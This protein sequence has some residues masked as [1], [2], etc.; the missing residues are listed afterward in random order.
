M[1]AVPMGIQG[2]HMSD[3]FRDYSF[4]GW[5]RHWRLEKEIGLREM[6][7]AIEKDPAHYCKIE[8]SEL[9]PPKTREDLARLTAPLKLN[10]DQFEM[11]VSLSY[12]H[13]LSKLK[14]KFK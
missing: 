14:E 13:H 8:K 4:G 6:S 2:D 7:R 1:P 12:Q 10:K 9:D 11:M 3:I 5:L